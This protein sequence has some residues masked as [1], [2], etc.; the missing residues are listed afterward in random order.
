MSDIRYFFK[1]IS[2]SFFPSSPGLY[3]IQVKAKVILNATA[4]AIIAQTTPEKEPLEGLTYPKKPVTPIEIAYIGELV[5]A[6]INPPTNPPSMQK[7][8]LFLTGN[9]TP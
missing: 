6:R 3:V 2:S 8:N 7:A 5:N 1:T 4:Q 9:V